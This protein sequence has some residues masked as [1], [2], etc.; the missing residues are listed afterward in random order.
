MANADFNSIILNEA[1]IDDSTGTP[2]PNIGTFIGESGGTVSMAVSQTTFLRGTPP[3]NIV[4]YQ[5]PY[6]DGSYVEK[7]STTTER[8]FSFT[9]EIHGM[10]GYD[11]VAAW[12][13]LSAALE[14]SREV[15]TLFKFQEVGP[16]GTPLQ[17]YV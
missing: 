15:P 1:S 9:Q 12:D 10:N 16:L 11:T 5:K 13:K 2:V 17:I 8:V 3:L 6:G 4:S 14:Y 7:N